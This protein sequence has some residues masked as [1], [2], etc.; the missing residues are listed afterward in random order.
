MTIQNFEFKARTNNL[1]DLEDAI[2]QFSPKF[3]GVDHQSDTYFNTINGRLK[4]R[5]GN[6]ENTL[7]WYERGNIAG[8]KASKVLLSNSPD[9]SIKQILTVAHGVKIIVEKERKIWFIDNVK[10]HFDKVKHLG[11]FVEV[12]A[13]DKD[14]TIG[15]EKLKQQC[16]FYSDQ[17]KILP[18][19]YIAES[20][21][22]M[23]LKD[24]EV[25][26]SST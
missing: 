22:D 4:L 23:L 13:I 2:K 26:T 12:E 8:A 3:A 6:I 15:L 5:E 10:F 17:F 21:S 9:K 20:Y 1:S 14:G 25:I 16:A 7:I 18:T 11:E 19:E 24:N